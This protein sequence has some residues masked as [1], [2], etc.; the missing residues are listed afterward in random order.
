MRVVVVPS[1]ARP[2]VEGLLAAT[3]WNIASNG[4]GE[5]VD[6]EAA[7]ARGAEDDAFVLVP[8][9]TTV[10]GTARRLLVLH[11]GTP[12][13]S[14]GVQ[15]A[16]RVAAAANGDVVV[17][18]VAEL[19]PPADPRGLPALR[20]ADHGPYDWEEW[21]DEFGRRFC[22]SSPGVALTLE[23]VSGPPVD[24]VVDVVAR[25]RVDLVVVTWK[26]ELGPGRAPTLRGL[27]RRSPAPL[28][29]LRESQG[30]AAGDGPAGTRR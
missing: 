13:A 3:G 10:A 2:N 21:R 18:H 30:D 17:L 20:V 7:L 1:S 23:V 22:P 9:G 24:A 15:V 8:P 11:D 12:V 4:V 19:A 14:P 16:S 5:E 26:G 25:E 6:P 27:A 29:V 28:L